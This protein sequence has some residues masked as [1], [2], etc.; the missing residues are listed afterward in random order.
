MLQRVIII[1]EICAF[2]DMLFSALNDVLKQRAP[3]LINSLSSLI[4]SP[5]DELQKINIGE[6]CAASGFKLD[7]DLALA[8]A[9]KQQANTNG[10][11]DP[12]EHYKISC[13]FIVFIAISLPHLALNP[14]SCYKASLSGIIFLR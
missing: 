8:N 7:V 14:Q 1:G 3:F 10:L 11:D 2:R 4:N 6:A 12:N 13:L 5:L 9:I